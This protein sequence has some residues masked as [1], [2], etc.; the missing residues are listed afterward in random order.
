M[1]RGRIAAFAS[2]IAVAAALQAA[3][4][5]ADDSASVGAVLWQP[6]M[7]VFRRFA[8]AR[9]QM[10]E[11]YGEV[12]GFEQLDTLNVGGG[13]GVARFR[14][15]AS[16]LKLTARV[17]NRQY[18][19]G[20]VR[21]A[22]GVRLLT[23]FFPDEAALAQRFIAHGRAAPEFITRAG[24]RR[25]ALVVD[26]D[27]QAVELVIVRDGGASDEVEVGLTVSDIESSRAFYREFVGLEELAPAHD[28]VFDTTKY[29][30]RHG[31][32]IVSLRSFGSELPADTGSGGIQ[33]VVSNVDVVDTLARAKKIAVDQPLSTL[34]GFQLRTIWLDD[35][36]GITNYFAETAQARAARRP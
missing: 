1:H 12:L 21:D 2:A 31:S 4:Y 26:P 35:P 8:V 10:F 20:G 32:T 34:G 6:S 5:G 19:P 13:N 25:S 28:P 30:Y 22:T 27:G 3:A 36:D 15:G 17:A 9:E 7:N 11:F 16:E 23:F 14:A 29:S 24:G 33:Y 18:V